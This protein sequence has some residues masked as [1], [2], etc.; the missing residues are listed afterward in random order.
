[1]R[2]K[3]DGTI[4]SHLGKDNRIV[5]LDSRIYSTV[6]NKAETE[7]GFSIWQTAIDT[8]RRVTKSLVEEFP[9]QMPLPRYCGQAVT[10]RF[11]INFMKMYSR[12][13]GHSAPD[14][15]DYKPGKYTVARIKNPI[16]MDIVAGTIL[17][18]FE[19]IN[20]VPHVC[21]IIKEK[22]NQFLARIEPDSHEGSC[23]EV[24]EVTFP[25]I[26]PGNIF[27]E[28]CSRCGVPTKLSDRLKWDH[29]EGTIV[30]TLTGKRFCVVSCTIKTVLEELAAEYGD[31]AYDF[32]MGAQRDLIMEHVK[33]RGDMLGP[34]SSHEDILRICRSYM[35]DWSLFGY[36]NPVLFDIKGDSIEVVVENP[37][38]VHIIAGALM[39][40]Y[41]AL[42]DRK[43]AVNWYM[44]KEGVV[45][46]A[47]E[48]V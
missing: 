13:A 14:L 27:Y 23:Q 1:M 26:L 32:L 39:G 7:L 45:S 37:F 48:P 31:A 34:E 44:P 47:I 28:R 11:M 41:D 6:F 8:T 35:D 2:W 12:I 3:S 40:L 29:E 46:Y 19:A 25:P 21:E 43:R 24:P 38:D 5:L 22:E 15:V 9:L 20:R 42:F 10:R 33:L 4:V 16:D 36:G 30:E 18:S 17:G